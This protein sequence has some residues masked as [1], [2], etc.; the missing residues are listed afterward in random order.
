M[1]RQLTK[2][3]KLKEKKRI[4]I[5]LGMAARAFCALIVILSFI[6]NNK[7]ETSKLQFAI[8]EKGTLESSVS[9][10]GK[11]SPLYEQSIVSPVATR[12][13]EVY[14]DEGDSVKTGQS[15]LRLDLLSAETELRR[16]A[17][18]VSLNG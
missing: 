10:S 5:S 9:A 12:I 7:L 6:F 18:E 11:I 1:D 2:K 13:L 16:L 4:Y 14:C 3:E 15:L 8:A 17:D